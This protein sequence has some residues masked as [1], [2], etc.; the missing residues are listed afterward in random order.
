MP[1]V[2]GAIAANGQPGDSWSGV[3]DGQS[4]WKAANRGETD[5]MSGAPWLD[6]GGPRRIPH[7]LPEL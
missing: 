4:G 7:S 3:E 6:L 5:N 1:A 2:R